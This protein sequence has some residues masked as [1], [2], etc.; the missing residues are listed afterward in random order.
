MKVIAIVDKNIRDTKF[1]MEVTSTELKKINY[2]MY[3]KDADK[4]DDLQ[5]NDEF[6]VDNMYQYYE[7]IKSMF[8]NMGQTIKEF[9][10]VK[11]TVYN[12]SRIFGPQIND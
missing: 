2:N 8:N 3:S 12:F 10:K 4:L 9:E 6:N 5:T 7:H 11:D 1:I